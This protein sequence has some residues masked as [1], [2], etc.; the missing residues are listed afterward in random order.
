MELKATPH[1]RGADDQAGQ[2]L[3][4]TERHRL[5]YLG[6]VQPE[7]PAKVSEK[8]QRKA[9]EGQRKAVIVNERL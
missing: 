9:S 3:K 5:G 8:G 7:V 4:Q 2:L 6:M 1:Q